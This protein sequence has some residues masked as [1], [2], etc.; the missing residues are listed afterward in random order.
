MILFYINLLW[1][2]KTRL[3][4]SWRR[5]DVFGGKARAYFFTAPA[6][7]RANSPQY[8]SVNG[9]H[10]ADQHDFVWQILELFTGGLLL[11]R[12]LRSLPDHVFQQQVAS[13]FQ[14]ADGLGQRQDLRMA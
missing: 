5:C 2:I 9:E 8:G 10:S 6:Q 13:L 4:I 7:E 11:A 3:W 14:L 12:R 1:F